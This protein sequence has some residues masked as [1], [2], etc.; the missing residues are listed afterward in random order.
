MGTTEIT[1]KE[2]YNEVH[3]HQ[4]QQVNHYLHQK[5]VLL[6]VDNVDSESNILDMGMGIQRNQS[7]R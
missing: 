3:L 7:Y 1:K 2:W 4:I 5:H 6:I